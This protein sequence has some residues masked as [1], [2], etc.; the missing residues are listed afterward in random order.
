MPKIAIVHEWLTGYAGSERV[1]EQLLLLYP[2]AD[3]FAVA[4]FLPPAE[5]HFLHGRAPRTTFLQRL[6]FAPRLLRPCFWLMPLAIEGLDLRGYDIVLSS[7][8]AVAKGVLTGP[9][10]FHLCYCH[11][12]IRYAWDLQPQYLEASGLRGVRR[13]IARALLHYMRL[14]DARTANGVDRFVANSRY[15]ARRIRKTYGREAAVLPPPVDVDAY[16]LN[17]A[18]REDF[19]LAAARMVPYKRMELIVDAFA[20]LLPGRRLVV[21]GSG[22]LEGECR[23]RAQGEARIAFR[24]AVEQTELV[25]LMRHARA[26]VF[27]A[28][29]DFGITVAEALACGTPVICYGRGG[30]TEM[31][32]NG[33]SGVYFGEQTAASLAAAVE[34]FE[35]TPL[36]TTPA[37]WRASVAG[38]HAREF[39]RRFDELLHEAHAAWEAGRQPRPGDRTHARA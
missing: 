2:Q 6:P 4:D 11:S 9:D 26:L 8:H 24:G 32:E 10:Q 14:W 7:S 38:L 21:V 13:G 3:L 15:V 36:A 33:G 22:P 29:E 35:Q 34:R 39:R 16:T 5:R 37:E 31:V 17:A 1:L 28:E 18:P 19:Y 20:R 23:R 12:P 25:R 27:A 30:A